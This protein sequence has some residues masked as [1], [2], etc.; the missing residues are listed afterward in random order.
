MNRLRVSSTFFIPSSSDLLRILSG[1]GKIAP[2]KIWGL[3]LFLLISVGS[4]TAQE[5]MTWTVDGVERFALVYPPTK[6]VGSKAPVVFGFHGG[7]DNAQHFSITEFQTG[8]PEALV[9]YVQALERTPGQGNTSY[10]NADPSPANSDLKLFDT[11]L[12]DLKKKFR[13]DDARIFA[14][15]FSNGGRFS[16]LLW[17]TRPKIFAGFAIVSSTIAP[18]VELKVPKPLMAI[19]GSQEPGHKTQMDSVEVV[20]KLNQATRPGE[21]CGGMCLLYRSNLAIPVL[22]IIHPNGHQYPGF[23]TDIIVRFFKSR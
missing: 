11:I 2:M 19:S 6:N 16:Y 22:T 7:G 17:A 18:N 1:S 10:Q 15:G 3:V 23:A 14:V 4:A 8:W 13:V 20:K 21:P 5:K 9:V 12:A